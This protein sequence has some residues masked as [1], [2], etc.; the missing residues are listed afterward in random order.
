MRVPELKLKGNVRNNAVSAD[1]S[2][3]GNSYNQ[4]DIPGIK[5]VLGRN[6]LNLKGALGD[7]LNLD[8][9]IDA[10]H[11]DNALPGL[12]G[13]AQGTLRARGDLKT[14][15]L[16]ADLTASGLRWQAMRIGRIKLDGDIRSGE[17]VQGKVNLRVEQLKQ[18]TLA[19][20]L[21]QLDASGTEKQH[22][23]KL[24]VQ[25]EPVAGQ[26]ALNGA[27]DRAA[28]RWQGALN[29]TRFATPVG[30]WRLT[31]A[32]ALDYLN[33]KQTVSIGPHCWQN[34]NA[35]L[36]VPQT[37]EAG[38]SGHARVVLSRFD[39]AMIK[40]FMPETTQ[41]A[42]VFNGDADVSWTADGGL[43]TGRVAL[44]GGG[45]RSSRTCRAIP[46]Q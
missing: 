40:P 5:L 13:A 20:S 1:G 24:N 15:Q 39:L 25:G 9:D 18:D 17:Q 30:D 4:W 31:R 2:L 14:P 45:L 8:A 34:P 38:P 36:C 12:G 44:K 6:N 16:L 27:F 46:C 21:L 19:V 29:H 33:A 26:L 41:L 42:G 28:G 3:S 11:L 23:L 43:P 22:Q 37:I 7:K 32:I 10:R 35:E